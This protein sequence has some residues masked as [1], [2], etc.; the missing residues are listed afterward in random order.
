MIAGFAWGEMNVIH[1]QMRPERPVVGQSYRFGDDPNSHTYMGGDC[2]CSTLLLLQE[3]EAEYPTNTPHLKNL[4]GL[5]IGTS[6]SPVVALSAG[7]IGD[8][9]LSLNANAPTITLTDKGIRKLAKSGRIC[10][11]F[12]HCFD[13][14]WLSDCAIIGNTPRKCKLCGKVETKVWK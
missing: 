10:E 4:P 11:I 14:E 7:V 3:S 6:S 12:G 8:L 9:T 5:I 2:W 1:L 13:N